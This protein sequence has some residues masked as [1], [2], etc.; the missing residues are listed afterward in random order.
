VAS[1]ADE[2]SLS[3]FRAGFRELRGRPVATLSG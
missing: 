1:D 2:G 3:R